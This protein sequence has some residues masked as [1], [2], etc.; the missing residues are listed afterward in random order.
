LNINKTNRVKLLI[1]ENYQNC[2]N[3]QNQVG[4]VFL[5][6][7]GNYV[8]EDE[9]NN[10]SIDN[11]HLFDN[12]IIEKDN[13]SY[14]EEEEKDKEYNGE[15]KNKDENDIE[16]S[17]NEVVEETKVENKNNHEIAINN[18]IEKNDKENNENNQNVKNNAAIIKKKKY[19]KKWKK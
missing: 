2:F 18:G 7:I 1:H 4:I 6:F 9:L 5:E 13:E 11:M 19:I 8:D 15:E 16:K 17:S 3:A 12:K 14:D 10:N